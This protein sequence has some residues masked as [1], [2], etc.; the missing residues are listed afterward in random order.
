MVCSNLRQLDSL[1]S[2]NTQFCLERLCWRGALIEIVAELKQS[3]KM[4]KEASVENGA[5]SERK[6]DD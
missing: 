5:D 1:S 2:S 4:L 6:M 3:T